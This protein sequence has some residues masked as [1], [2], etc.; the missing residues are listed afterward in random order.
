[1]SPTARA[2][3][4][5]RQLLLPDVG[6]AGQARL[7]VA[8][9]LVV[10]CGGLG[11]PVVQYL[12][13][14]GVGHLTLCDDDVVELSNLNRQVLHRQQDVGRSKAERAAEW[15]ADLDDAVSVTAQRGRLGVH[16]A[17]ELARAHDLV[18]DC[19]D[20]LP[21]KY[22][23]ND[24]CVLED[25]PLV[26]GAATAFDGQVLFVPGRGGPCL[27]CLF[28]EL[29]PAG[30]VPSCQE[31]GV[32]GATTG[33][34]GSLMVVEAVKHLVGKQGGGGRFVSV[35]AFGPSLRALRFERQADCPACGEA[36]E[37]DAR[38]ADDYRPP[39][40]ERPG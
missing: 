29:P 19:T 23:L 39:P 28:E 17:R 1:M 8:R 30:S 35:D 38:T 2:E 36:P 7:E 3:R 10:G 9:V 26:H 5:S 21:A 31:A 13:A 37:V 40:C 32:L 25:R 34:V 33:L 24:A 20:G 11:A 27:R 12:A 16:D 15:V 18:M 4:H 22:L 6:P 14:A